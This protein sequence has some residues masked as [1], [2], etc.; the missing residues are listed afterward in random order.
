MSQYQV[1]PEELA[2]LAGQL[3]TAATNINSESQAARDKVVAIEG[4]WTGAASSQFQSLFAEWKN[5]ADQVQEA[6]AGI[7]RLLR[8]A[9]EAYD[10]TNEQVRQSMSQ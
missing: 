2:S 9:G 5:G 4:S 3:D 8:G 1:T 6:L 10:T 7:S